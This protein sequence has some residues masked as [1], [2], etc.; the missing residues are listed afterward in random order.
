MLKLV[1]ISFWG[2]NLI[3][4][5]TGWNW[6]NSTLEAITDNNWGKRKQMSP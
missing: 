4:R 6:K 5:K 1:A 3:F 2:W